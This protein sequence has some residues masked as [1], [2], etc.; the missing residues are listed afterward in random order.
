MALSAEDR[1]VRARKKAEQ[2]LED[3][4]Q[5]LAAKDV[6]EPRGPRAIVEFTV[7][8]AQTYNYV[9]LKA[10]GQWYLTGKMDAQYSWSDIID[11]ADPGSVKVVRH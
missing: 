2:A 4:T 1:I 6:P 9:G 11:M 10:R 3:L 7:T 5:A 8:Y